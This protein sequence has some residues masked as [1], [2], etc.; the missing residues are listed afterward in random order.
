[1]V[2]HVTLRQLD[3]ESLKAL[4]EVAVSDADPDETMPPM[5]GNPGWTPERREKFLEFFRPMLAGLDGPRATLI[6]AI[7][8][9][10][11]IAGFIRLA[12]TNRDGV[13]ETGIWLGRSWRGRGLATGA[14]K[15]LL[16]IAAAQGFSSIVAD[17][18]PENTAALGALRRL[19]ATLR[20]HA[21][22][23]IGPAYAPDLDK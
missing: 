15:E 9:D 2:D 23:I 1:M 11:A 8:V 21:E 18:S 13:A 16:T 4:L 19:G 6:Y 12:R 17:T 3:E 20:V 7:T 10:E 22:L 14:L 5:P